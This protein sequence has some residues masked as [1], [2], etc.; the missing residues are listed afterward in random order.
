MD[1]VQCGSGT[2]SSC[3]YVTDDNCGHSEDV[4]LACS[5]PVDGG[6]T[7]FGE[8]SA[9]SASCGDGTQTRTR[10]CSNPAPANG[11]ADCVG[12][13]SETRECREN[14]CPVF[15]LVDQ[16][17]NE[18]GARVEGLLLSNG[19]TVCDDGFSDNSADAIC[20]EMGFIGRRSWRNSNQWSSFQET[21]DITL[22]DVS[23]SSG[24]WSSCTYNFVD[25][26]GHSEDLYLE[27]DGP[28]DGGYTDF[29]DWSECSKTCGDGTQ[30]RTRTCSN[31][32]PANGGAECV[33]AASET[34]ACRGDT[35]C[36]E[37]S[38]V[39]GNG[40]PVGSRVLGLLLNNGGTVCDDGFSALSADAICREMGYTGH[41]SFTSGNRLSIQSTLEIKLD[42]VVCREG[43]WTT[44]SY[45]FGHNCGHNEDV[46]LECDVVGLPIDG[47]WS[48]HGD[49]GECSDLCDSGVQTRTKTCTNPRPQFGGMDCVGQDFETRPCNP[50]PCEGFAIQ[51]EENSSETAE[52][53]GLLLY[54]GG[55]V[56]DDY[57]NDDAANAICRELGFGKAISWRNGYLWGV[58]QDRKPIHLDD[59]QCSGDRRW[60]SC[61][62]STTH[63]CGHGED[64]FLTCQDFTLVDDEGEPIVG[65]KEGILLYKTGTVCDTGFSDQSASALCRRMGFYG[66][67]SWRSGPSQEDGRDIALGSVRCSSAAWSSCELSESN[68]CSHSNDVFLHCYTFDIVDANG[69]SVTDEGEGL[70]IYKDGT[71][72]DDSF[73]DSSVDAICREMGFHAALSWRNG[74]FYNVQQDARAIRLDDVACSSDV[75]TEC[76]HSET[77]NCN[78]HEDV[79]ISCELATLRDGGWTDFG[80][81]SECSEACDTGTQTR[82]RTCTNPAPRYGGAD[83]EGAASQTRRCNPYPC[84][85][86]VIVDLEGNEVN[87]KEE[88][89]LLYGGGTVC[90]D[91]FNYNAANAICK[92]LGFGAASHWASAGGWGTIQGT[93]QINLDDVRCS[94]DGVWSS[95]TY[96]TGHNCG[97]NED[98]LL[99]CQNFALVDESGNPV[100]GHQV[101]GLLLYQDG[102][103]SGEDLS[104]TSA[105]AICREL[106][107]HEATA[108]RTGL[109]YGSQQSGRVVTMGNVVC[110]SDVWSECSFDTLD[111]ASGNHD[112]DVL[113]SCEYA[114]VCVDTEGNGYQAGQGYTDD[115]NPQKTCTCIQDGSFVCGCPADNA[116]CPGGTSRWTDEETC[117]SR[118]IPGPA[119]CSSS[120]DPHYLSFDGRYFDF[121]GQCTYQALSCDDFTVY[122][123]NVDL[124]RSPIRY[125]QR[126]EL[127]FKGHKFVIGR[128]A[129]ATVDGVRVQTPYVKR[130]TNGDRVELVHNGQ[131]EIRLYSKN[132]D[133]SVRMRSNDGNSYINAEI[134]LHG[135]CAGMTE[136]LCG[137]WNGDRWDDLLNNDPNAQG[138]LFEQYDEDCPAPPPPYDPCEQI[139]PNARAEAEAICNTLTE[140]PFTPCQNAV[141]VGTVKEGLL[142]TCVTDVCQ[143]N[144]DN[145]CACD[146]LE[147]YAQQCIENG[148]DL[149]NWRVEV[150]FC[151]YMCPDG[152]EYASNRQ[153]PLPSCLDRSPASTGTQRGCFCAEGRFLQDGVC[154]EPD[155]CRC[156]HEGVFY[157]NG[158]EIRDEGACQVCTCEDAGEMICEEMSCPDLDCADDE[159]VGYREDVCCPYCLADWVEAVN[160]SVETRKGQSVTLTCDIHVTGVSSKNVFWY[161]DGERVNSAD[162]QLSTN[163]RQLSFTDAGAEDRGTFTCEATKDGKTSSCDFA[164]AVIIPVTCRHEDGTEFE[165]GATYKPNQNTVCSCDSRG[166]ISCSCIDNPSIQ[167]SAPTAG[168][169]FDEACNKVCVL[170]RATCRSYNDPHYKSFDGSYYDFHGRCTYQAASCGDFTVKLKNKDLGGTPTYTDIM[171]LEFKG[172]TFAIHSEGYS[173]HVDDTQVQVPFYKQWNNGDIVSILNN[174]QLQITLYSKGREPSARLTARMMGGGRWINVE[175][176]LHGSCA[177]VSE[178]I[179]GI[180]DGDSSNEFIDNDVNAH[181]ARYLVWQPG[182][183]EPPPAFHPCDDL[184]PGFK[185]NARAVCETMAAAPFA[186]CNNVIPVGDDEGGTIYTCMTE[187]CNCFGDR[188]CACPEFD[189][190]AEEC[191]SNGVDLSNWRQ[192]VEFCPYECPEGRTYMANGPVPTPTCLDKDPEQTGTQRGCFCPRGQFLQDGECVDADQCLCIHEG[193][194]YN[195]GD[196]IRD[197]GACQVCTCE[198]AGEMICN[199]IVCPELTCGAD[200]LVAYRDDVCCPFCI[201][202][203]VQSVNPEVQLEAGQD[204]VLTCSLLVPNVNRKSVVWRRDGEV[205]TEGISRSRLELTIA[206]TDSGAYTCSATKDGVTDSAEFDVNPPPVVPVDGGYTDFGGWSAC[207][208]ICGFGTQTRRRTCTNPAPANGGADCVGPDSEKRECKLRECPVNGGYSDFGDWSECSAECGGGTQT[209]SRTCTNP[210]PANGGLDCE[211]DSTET[212]E[213]NTNGCE[214]DGGYSDFGDWSECSAECGGGTQTRSRTCTNPAP[215]NGGLDCVGDSAE[216]RECNTQGCPVDG[217]YSDFGDWSECSAECGGGTQT[218]SRTCTNPAPANGGADCEGDSTETRECNT[219]GCPVDGGYSDYGDWSE[220]SAKCGGGTKTKTRTCTNPAP[221][222][223]GAD[224]VGD[225]TLTRECNKRACPIDGGYSDFGE[226]SECSGVCGVAGTQRRFRTCTNPAPGRGG[227]GCRL[228]G[229]RVEIR[230]C[231]SADCVII[232]PVQPTELECKIGKWGCQPTFVVRKKKKKT[233]NRNA[234]KVCRM[235]EGE[236]TE[237]CVKPHASQNSQYIMR[238]GRVEAELAGAYVAVYTEDGIE[239]VSDPVTVTVS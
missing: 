178:G 170:D 222:N 12:A 238:S 121:H 120:G 107:Y 132:R 126:M 93:K 161:K 6:Y 19:G 127:E 164:V 111:T 106:G 117:E 182:C 239:H 192:S 79:H 140:S 216:T 42:D 8:W 136:G 53:E 185:D 229:P 10:T 40:N 122:F 201:A 109:E 187:V 11:G 16:N 47:G 55:T 174:G 49:W 105:H 224:C 212:R 176:D 43:E 134:W 175:I 119:Y 191:I 113:L 141:P 52:N 80:D 62:F 179:C 17:G 181:A 223:G 68:S 5:G 102:T 87:S 30:T 183:P 61:S 144:L 124:Y 202:D 149:S 4:F 167:C 232:K 13:A 18:V 74:Y 112:D 65:Q 147:V 208:R 92:E 213:C 168:V 154:V 152:L 2:W 83:C 100:T 160:P 199:D 125:T 143:C 225:S 32:A 166:R 96:L 29:G 86:F 158:D 64:V 207:S 210:A 151:P 75:W 36:L 138:Q 230:D 104:E 58:I 21:F 195:N 67:K 227:A 139:G 203:W 156:L 25:N 145:S 189:N 70:L 114:P 172:H 115:L 169:W 205:V 177:A 90:D 37:F 63:N 3:T 7:D 150:E 78:H 76:S 97:H 228:L 33:G 89:L 73:S 153:V 39:D 27:C 190:Y 163:K 103:V 155:Q 235:V 200:N 108:W 173:V 95:C 14:E 196:E 91:F 98:V 146:Q 162:Y 71:V 66:A 157:N 221:A 99:E 110:T 41:I 128:R 130:F 171:T 211:G 69:I 137:N 123:K 186:Q 237:D 118:C 81:W 214:V 159:L 204:A 233:V 194:F 94:E 72:C 88:G 217:G 9:C 51:F 60:S 148:V 56:C 236:V 84:D 82:T 193:I 35:E 220:C 22:D 129:T 209:R 38:L 34:R 180:W 50:Y 77:H 1:D 165:R 231:V 188:S 15:S 197:E 116:V 133:P 218:G 135:S 23:C 198:D 101:E 57:F 28:V 48:E 46:F 26:C 226:W 59:V 44:C 20:R 54:G 184:G 131:L 206:S 24:E 219:Q 31:P 45:I 234:V 142:A 85:G 215:A